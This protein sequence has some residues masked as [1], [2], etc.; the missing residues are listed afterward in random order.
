MP[1]SKIFFILPVSLNGENNIGILSVSAS[2]WA[3]VFIQ[4]NVLEWRQNDANLEN[5]RAMYIRTNDQVMRIMKSG[6]P[7]LT[8]QIFCYWNKKYGK[9]STCFENLFPNAKILFFYSLL[10]ETRQ[11]LG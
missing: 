8:H 7:L 3:H 2:S 9:K 6:L 10:H 4:K 5:I 11:A 1:L